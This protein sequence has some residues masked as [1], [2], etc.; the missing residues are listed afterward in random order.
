M[1]KREKKNRSLNDPILYPDSLPFSHHLLL[2]FCWKLHEIIWKIISYTSLI[3]LNYVC[4]CLVSPGQASFSVSILVLWC[5]FFFCF[6]VGLPFLFLCCPQRPTL[7]CGKISDRPTDPKIKR[8]RLQGNN[9]T[10]FFLWPSVCAEEK[11]VMI[12]S[13]YEMFA[14]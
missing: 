5:V 8:I 11:G 4:P 10:T 9:T 12:F 6:C 2:L 3:L 14:I 7:K 13:Q 1:I